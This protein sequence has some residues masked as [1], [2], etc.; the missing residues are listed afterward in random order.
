MQDPVATGDRDVIGRTE[1][2][3]LPLSAQI[4]ADYDRDIVSGPYFPGP[5]CRGLGTVGS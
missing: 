3:A 5:R 1:T 4:T 2:L